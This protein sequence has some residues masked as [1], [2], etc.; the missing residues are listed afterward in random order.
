MV[1]ESI[2]ASERSGPYLDVSIFAGFSYADVPNGGFSLVVVADRYH[3]AAF[4]SL[5]VSRRRSGRNGKPSIIGN[6]FTQSKV[7]SML[8]SN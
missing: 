3:S 6:W 2:V 5:P 8:R 7:A 4:V 1:L